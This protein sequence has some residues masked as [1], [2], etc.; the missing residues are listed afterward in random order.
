M[1]SSYRNATRLSGSVRRGLDAAIDESIR[2][3]G[4]RSASKAHPSQ[5]KRPVLAEVAKYENDRLAGAVLR[6]WA[7]SQQELQ[8][9]AERH[10]RSLGLPVD[11]PNRRQGVFNG[12]WPRLE[13]NNAVDMIVQQ[14]PEFDGD[15]VGM[16]VCYLSGMAV[17]PAVTSP[18]LTECIHQ[19]GELSLDA[20]D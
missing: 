10:L 1:T 12:L 3:P 2:V 14:N 6:A 11:G 20:P 13:R 19:L 4:F 16:M 18:L 17:G 7:E 9:I 5:L 15:D 8:A